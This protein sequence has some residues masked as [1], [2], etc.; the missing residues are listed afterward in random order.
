[1][2]PYALGLLI[3]IIFLLSS[4]CYYTSA[5]SS[6][7]VIDGILDLSDADPDSFGPLE[8][9]GKWDFF[10]NQFVSAEQ[11]LNENPA[12]APATITLPA[13]WT[14]T[15]KDSENYPSKGYA[16]YHLKIL[17][18][19]KGLTL[20]L[21][22]KDIFTAY[23]LYADDK[24]IVK[25]GNPADNEKTFKPAF[26]SRTVFFTAEST[27][28]HLT[29]HVSNYFNRDAG[30]Q[31]IY[32]GD[33]K[34]IVQ[35][36]GLS[37]ATD[38]I[39]FGA[40]ILFGIYHLVLFLLRRK[41]LGILFF[42]IL[43]FV[44]A[45][46]IILMGE[47][48]LFSITPPGMDG[49]FFLLEF[50]TVPLITIFFALF[51]YFQ[52]K[53]KWFRIFLYPGVGLSVLF[54]GIIF[55]FPLPVTAQL[56]SIFHLIAVSLGLAFIAA[57]A[58]AIRQKKGGAV[59]F[60]IGFCFFLAT[61]INDMLFFNRMITTFYMIPFGIFLFLFSQAYILSLTFTRAF[62]SVE[63]LSKRLMTLDKL[64]DAYLANTSHE[65]KTPLEGM[66]NTTESILQGDSGRI[67][68]EIAHKLSF[69]ASHGRRLSNLVND[70]LDFTQI[71]YKELFLVKKPVSM[72]ALCKTV[73]LFSRPLLRNKDV[74]L[75]N[76]I[77]KNFPLVFGDPVRLQQILHNL[78]DNAV[79][80]TNKGF[81]T[82]S[83]FKM[84]QQA[85]FSVE[86]TG[87]GIPSES[88]DLVFESFEQLVPKVGRGFGGKGL[89][90]AISK[91]LVEL[92]GGTISV[93]SSEGKGS[94][95]TFSLPISSIQDAE[96]LVVEPRV[97]DAEVFE[98]QESPANE[99][100]VLHTVPKPKITRK[101]HVLVI[102]NDPK[103][104]DYIA[105]CLPDT[106]FSTVLVSTELEGLGAIS[107]DEFDIVLVDQMMQQ[108]SPKGFEICAKI[109]LRKPQQELPVIMMSPRQNDIDLVRG[110]EVGANDFIHKPLNASELK[111]R[112]KTHVDLSKLQFA[113][114]R[115]VPERFLE[116]LGKSSIADVSPGDQI[117]K[118][119]TIL[120]CDIRSFM[121]F[122][123]K[124]SPQE[125]FTFLNSYYEKISPIIRR[126]H[127]FIDKYIG[128]EIMALFPENPE[129]ALQASLEIK[130][131]IDTY[132]T[133]RVKTGYEP[134]TIGIGIHSGPM[135]LGTIG[136]NTRLDG[137]VI[138][139]A[140]NTASRLE[141]LTKQY[142]GS[143]IISSSI[144]FALQDPTLYFY[145][146]LGLV[147]VKGKRAT[148]PIYEIYDD[149]EDGKT[150]HA[151]KDMFE[152]AL[153]N[154][155]KKDF[156]EASSLF[157]EILE[158]NQNDKAA[159]LFY[160]RSEEYKY[161]V[162]DED[163]DGVETIFTK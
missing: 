56:L 67:N 159:R 70:I 101:L 48:L 107:R 109:R 138:S 96:P 42:S 132:N 31:R 83:A 36:R 51:F 88:L 79:K 120:F 131:S 128:D 58:D 160:N 121:T 8:L 157:K 47:R 125:T 144:F 89:G 148:V 61:A 78:I 150:K 113:Y 49:F 38:S 22:M 6:A 106:E 129:D 114:S 45:F 163:W 99:E 123:E 146:F 39:L 118:E 55:I 139:D 94:T 33:E 24:L 18:P 147:Q 10:W 82:V 86:D 122:S 1:M 127:G 54:C 154:Y 133:F 65:L 162:V 16:T 137:T 69:V 62:N 23:A 5:R 43:C 98:E 9:S 4:A 30:I 34:T 59:F 111:L 3:I 115:F 52:Y 151:T 87:M 27:V 97:D 44:V 112:I 108:K 25:N 158:K 28:M 152:Q 103:D 124:M 135:M 105:T 81:V 11:F 7:S 104:L 136:D 119:M 85:F 130:K 17:L 66:V 71:K 63:S 116:L 50:L 40:L 12:N 126:H 20:G 102:D 29:F 19:Q 32:F 74:E 84:N 145:R 117:Q 142:G 13:F 68:E 91:Y 134:V 141:G 95:F 76:K 41:E 77:P 161:K 156:K 140:V 110:I 53:I 149:S 21:A 90:L 46:R 64:K 93:N 92:H 153:S 100:S 73:F 14:D 2:K 60:L 72:H 35:A 80:F 155:F 26:S 57:L 15:K 75:E 143:I 37:I